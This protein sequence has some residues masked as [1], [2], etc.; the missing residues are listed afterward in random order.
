M[1]VTSGDRVLIHL[2]SRGDPDG[3]TGGVSDQDLIASMCGIGRTHIPRVL[4]PLLEDDLILEEMGRVPGKPRRVKVYSLTEEGLLTS[5]EALDRVNEETVYWTDETGRRRSGKALDCLEKINLH[6]IELSMSK[7][8]ASLFLSLPVEDL[9]WNDIMW[10]SASL[11]EMVGEGPCIPEGWRPLAIR[12]RFKG[13]SFD[14]EL[15][16]RMD[17]HLSDGMVILAGSEDSGKEDLIELWARSRGRKALWLERG[18]DDGTC[19]DGGPW[20]LIVLLGGADRDVDSVLKGSMKVNDIR[21]GHWPREF[22]SLD[23]I[24]TTS[25]DVEIEGPVISVQGLS[26]DFF[27]SSCRGR[28]MGEE[29]ALELYSSTRGS[30]KALNQILAMDEKEISDLSRKDIEEAVISIL[31]RSKG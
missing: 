10:T 5:R 23:L 12:E 6:L 14:R 31:L 2:L 18:D 9:S 21:N 19:L 8:P 20:D 16:E 7:L 26:M 11:R 27:V 1:P 29:M 3:W 4:K 25:L 15:L 22:R 24:M 13:L 30:P 28:G 17:A